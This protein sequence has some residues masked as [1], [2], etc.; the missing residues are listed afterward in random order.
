MRDPDLPSAPS[1]KPALEVAV[2]S[3]HDAESFGAIQRAVFVDLAEMEGF[4]H[5]LPLRHLDDPTLRADVVLWRSLAQAKQAADL[6][7]TDPRFANFLQG[8]QE[9]KHFHHF[10]PSPPEALEAIASAPVVEIAT[11]RSPADK[12]MAALQRRLHRVLPQIDGVVAHLAG[13]NPEDPQ[14]SLDLIAWTRREAF[15]AA[16][17][18]LVAARPELAS[19][20]EGAETL[21]LELF[22][23]ER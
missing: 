23:L 8:I 7:P 20:F 17:A 5:G 18:A 10:S 12:P 16:P 6:L 15:E 22:E 14:I 3:V 21:L 1:E 9:V 2:Y 4:V 11:F 19:F 13:R